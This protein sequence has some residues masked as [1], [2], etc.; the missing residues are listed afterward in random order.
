MVEL[1]SLPECKLDSVT[2]K[3]DVQKKLAHEQNRDSNVFFNFCSCAI[4]I[5]WAKWLN[6]WFGFFILYLDKIDLSLF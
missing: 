1:L 6:V 5:D 4:L 2:L 3:I